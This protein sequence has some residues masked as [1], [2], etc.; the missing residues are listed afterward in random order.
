MPEISN[1]S[2]Q[3]AA[4]GEATKKRL[5]S[6]GLRLFGMKG[7]D[8]VSIR[9][10][11][12]EAGVNPGAIAFHYQGKKGLYKAVLDMVIARMRTLTIPV[13][14]SLNRNIS[15]GRADFQYVAPLI[16]HMMDLLLHAHGR[17]ENADY[18]V[19][20]VQREL[21]NPTPAFERL[22]IEAFK[23]CMEALIRLAEIAGYRRGEIS[24]QIMA[25]SLA[26]LPLSIV[27]DKAIVQRATGRVQS[28]H[29]SKEELDAVRRMFTRAALA[30]LGYPVPAVCNGLSR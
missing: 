23:P 9:E 30:M 12:K 4:R 28:G 17:D 27:R 26:S 29:Y 7:Y 2:D 21:S 10:I 19:M 20:M 14:E 22:F 8:A 13:A 5:V 6:V 18:V 3:R 16:S 24:T 11:A 25:C 15:N 1:R